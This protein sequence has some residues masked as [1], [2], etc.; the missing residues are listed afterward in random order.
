MLR[1]LVVDDR[2]ERTNYLKKNLK[3]SD[4]DPYKI[5][6]SIKTGKSLRGSLWS[7]YNEIDMIVLMLILA[8]FPMINYF[9]AAISLLSLT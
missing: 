1:V 9:V 8:I 4:N 6:A 3:G 7:Y 5:E 2:E